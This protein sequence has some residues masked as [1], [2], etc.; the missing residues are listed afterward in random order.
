[1]AGEARQTWHGNPGVMT[2]QASEI[3]GY[4]AGTW[5]IDLPVSLRLE[6]HGFAP[7]AGGATRAA[8][9]ASGQLNRIDF[10]VCTNPPITGLASEKVQLDIEAGAVLRGQP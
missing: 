1:M 7:D 9:S 5:D 10:G 8:F 6:V 4:I 2:I 3:P